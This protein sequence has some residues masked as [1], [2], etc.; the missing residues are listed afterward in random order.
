VIGLISFVLGGT[1]AMAV[2]T[3]LVSLFTR[4]FQVG[5]PYRLTTVGF[6]YAIAVVLYAFGSADGGPI[7]WTAGIIPYGIG[8]L[9]VLVLWQLKSMRN[10]DDDSETFE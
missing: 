5:T 2:L 3:G 7:N 10:R 1:I 4:R 6:A 8:A 9:I